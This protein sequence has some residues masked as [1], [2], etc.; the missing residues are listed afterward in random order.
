M[1]KLLGKQGMRMLEMITYLH[2]NDWVTFE[3]ISEAIGYSERTLRE[4]IKYPDNVFKLIEIV[5]ST[6]LGAK[7]L[8]PQGYSFKYIHFLLLSD[9]LH[10]KILEAFFC[11]H[12]LGLLSWLTPCIPVRQLSVR[13]SVK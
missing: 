8:I 2:V 4:D 13:R 6:K 9:S 7:L 10:F 12:I 3:K 5:A 1:K 11:I